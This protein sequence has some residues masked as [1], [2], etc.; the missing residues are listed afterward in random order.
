MGDNSLA[1]GKMWGSGFVYLYSNNYKDRYRFYLFFRKAW[2]GLVIGY[3]PFG[4]VRLWYLDIE[5][6]NVRALCLEW[7]FPEALTH[8]KM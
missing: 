2:K 5:K 7:T 1:D 6:Q 3:M 8:D 4:G